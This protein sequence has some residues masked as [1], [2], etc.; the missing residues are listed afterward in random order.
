MLPVNLL[1]LLLLFVGSGCAAL[2]YEVVWLPLLQQVIGSSAVSLAV[3][4]ATYMGGM[5]L[6][7]LALPR[8]V[9]P[10]F[11]PLRVFA[12]IELGIGLCGILVLTLV[13]R[14]DLIYPAIAMSGWPGVVIRAVVSAACLLPPTLLMG[15]SLPAIAR[16]VQ[17]TS[18]E[19]SWLGYFYGGNIAGAV[20]GALLAGFY[21]LRRYD[22]AVASHVAVGIN[23]VVAVAAFL[24]AR[25]TR[26]PFETSGRAGSTKVTGGSA[27]LITIALSGFVALGA[28]VL[29]TRLLSL[30][31]GATVYAFSIILGVFLSGLGVGSMV[32]AAVSRRLQTSRLMLG[33][34]QL[35]LV[36]SLTWGAYAVAVLVP[37]PDFAPSLLPTPALLF[38]ENL[39]RTAWVV[40]PSAILWGASFP[41]ALAALENKVSDKSTLVSVVYAANT[42]GAIFGALVMSLLLIPG[43]GTLH[44][45]QA[46]IA[47]SALAAAVALYGQWATHRKRLALA[48]TMLLVVAAGVGGA[49]SVQP[50]P[51]YAIAYGR[52]M[53]VTG[54][55]A[56]ISPLYIGEGM[57]ATIAVSARSN[58]W[59]QYH[60][61]GKVEATSDPMDMRLERLLGHLSALLAKNPED[62]LVVGFG[63]GITAG[64]FVKHPE[65][66][67]IVIDEIEPLVPPASTEWFGE[68]NYR[69][70]LDPRTEMNFDDARHFI[71]T[72]PR[73]FDVITSDPIHPWVKGMA[74]LYSREY[75]EMCKRHLKPGGVVTQWIPLYE[76][77]FETIRT[78]LATFFAVFPNATLWNS[79]ARGV[80]YD[81]VAVGQADPAPIDLAALAEKLK[82]PDY[83]PVVRS[84][85]EVGLGTV[86]QILATYAG[87][88]DE[89]RQWTDGA[90]INTDLNLRLQY[91]AGWS[92]NF[93]R[94][95]LI[96]E[97]ILSYRVMPTR[98]FTGPLPQ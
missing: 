94:P 72:T 10:R 23:V 80:G 47:L 24:I 54:A 95:D 81:L 28:E 91:L 52:M 46:L 59:R 11:H 88:E 85:D 90:A 66:K 36:V 44:A 6:G 25:Q 9:S 13:P 12:A 55:I 26:M 64:A 17:S 93:N 60:V 77:S 3:L 41:L 62:I 73:K 5:F 74:A 7:S 69:V 16:Y 21:L 98:Q 61:S 86:P 83:Q 1:F 30:M 51:F 34:A 89:L 22:M 8:V 42:V 31:L 78:E 96:Y 50:L 65:V 97:K 67:H 82:R 15:A 92:M 29:W 37:S 4:L 40:L 49:L 27:I 75:F 87:R 53:N 68:Q 45:Q 79:D 48:I 84:L 18:K 71:L 39:K 33:I 35:L 76:N 57:N 43:I 70:L 38:L 58:G 2:I 63:A 14:F 56:P 32:G 20:L 19:L